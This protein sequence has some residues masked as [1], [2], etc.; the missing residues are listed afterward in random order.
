VHPTAAACSADLAYLQAEARENV[1]GRIRVSEAPQSHRGQPV[2]CLVYTVAV[3]NQSTLHI[4][5]NTA[6]AELTK[7]EE[8]RAN[9]FRSIYTWNIPYRRG[10]MP[11]PPKYT[12]STASLWKY[13]FTRTPQDCVLRDPGW[14][15]LL[16]LLLLLLEGRGGGV[17]CWG[18][19]AG[20]GSEKDA[21]DP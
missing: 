12:A 18:G 16:L 1:Q 4:C 10:F 14:P 21:G 6:I 11:H 7:Q 19:A 13:L 2:V 15:L 17:R 3:S 8:K 9:N 5:S 20:R